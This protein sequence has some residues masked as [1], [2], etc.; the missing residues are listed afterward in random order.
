MIAVNGVIV[1]TTIEPSVS[2]I[3]RTPQVNTGNTGSSRIPSVKRRIHR[4]LLKKLTITSSCF[5]LKFVK[6]NLL[7]AALATAI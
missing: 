3:Y 4:Y 7:A 1:T 2:F 5:D 6:P